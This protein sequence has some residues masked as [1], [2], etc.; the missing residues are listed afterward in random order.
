MLI[1]GT[2][3]RITMARGRHGYPDGRRRPARATID[4]IVREALDTSY[5]IDASI[6]SLLDESARHL[7]KC[8]R[9][10]DTEEFPELTLACPGM[11]KIVVPVAR[12]WTTYRTN[13]TPVQ[14]TLDYTER[15]A[16][17]DDSE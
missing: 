15:E 17:E 5:Y 3:L 7:H 14:Q 6:V 13:S 1:N 4:D 2:A 9:C 16:A 10:Q 12:W 8:R 11:Q